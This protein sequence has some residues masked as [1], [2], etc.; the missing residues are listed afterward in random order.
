MNVSLEKER[1]YDIDWIRVLVFDSLILYHV[2]MFF[3]PWDW[4]LKNN[5]TVDWIKW[6][7]LFINRWRLPILF[8]IS[9][10]G[11]RFALSYRSG[12][13]FAKERIERLFIPL[14]IGVL[15]IV[16]PQIY[17]VRL[18]EGRTYTSYINFYPDFFN[19]TYPEGNF[20]WGHLWFLPYLLVMSFVSIPTFI[21][22]RKKD[23]VV[24]SRFREM[25]SY[26]PFTLFLFVVP[27]FFS[28]ILLE[29]YFPFTHGLVGDWYALTHYFICF[30]AGYLFASA[31][32]DFWIGV[33][34]LKFWSLIT[35]IVAFTFLIWSWFNFDNI[36]I[37][38][39]LSSINR[40]SW[41]LA[42][43][44]FSATYLNRA[45]S[46]IKYRTQAVYPF[47]I[48]HQTIIILLGF[49]LMDGAMPIFIKAIIMVVGTYGGC[50]LIYEFIIRRISFIKP[51]F[52]VK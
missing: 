1:R 52:G 13:E 9:G 20:S 40:W 11:T 51:M 22:L 15:L 25:L 37:A 17:L 18:A 41:I 33:M 26:T 44:G 28:D 39:L 19:G 6:P 8:V 3:A 35:G 31:G 36:Y 5:V 27:L 7:M 34:R 4:E 30:L 49:Y 46:V 14:I 12:G 2:A 43:F 42:I 23:N 48:L 29:P 38:G 24:I 10:I 47:Y 16:A 45:S 32:S 21:Y 50:W